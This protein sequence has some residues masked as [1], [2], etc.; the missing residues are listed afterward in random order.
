[1]EQNSNYENNLLNLAT[2]LFTSRQTTSVPEKFSL[3]VDRTAK[4]ITTKVPSMKNLRNLYSLHNELIE[5]TRLYP[6]FVDTNYWKNADFLD[7]FIKQTLTIRGNHI[8]K[9]VSLDENTEIVNLISKYNDYNF[10]ENVFDTGDGWELP[11]DF[12]KKLAYGHYIDMKNS[13]SNLFGRNYINNFSNSERINKSTNDT[14][15][16][17]ENSLHRI[18]IPKYHVRLMIFNLTL[19][20][21]TIFKA[22]ENAYIAPKYLEKVVSAVKKHYENTNNLIKQ[23]ILINAIK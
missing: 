21:Q 9:Y 14:N 23:D 18:D 12:T 6:I 16:E 20:Q 2:A 22:M 1:M 3:L 7:N 4:E 5:T 17:L 10:K 11:G 15:Y 8:K 13:I 19:S